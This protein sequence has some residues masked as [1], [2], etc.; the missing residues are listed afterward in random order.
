MNVFRPT[1]RAA[2]SG[3][4]LLEVIIVVGLL[5]M[6]MTLGLSIFVAVSSSWNER[7][8][9]QRLDEVATDI[10]ESLDRD[11]SDALSAEL[12]GEALVGEAN[13]RRIPGSI[14]PASAADDTLTLLVQGTQS[15]DEWHHSSRVRYT[16]DR[17]VA[18]PQLVRY[19]SPL[20]VDNPNFVPLTPDSV[21][22]SAL[23]IQYASADTAEWQDAWSQENH[24]A[25]VRVSL[26]L[27]SVARPDI[28]I[29]RTRVF[30]VHVQ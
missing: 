8:V 29:A 21:A 5:G 23:R 10:F 25:A 12:S 3:F 7:S 11:F 2:R 16:I 14:P 9:Q 1:V 17:S 24:P 13:S 27:R 28:Q 15:R 4:T 22:I 20:N 6:V 26:A 30:A 19:D 18:E